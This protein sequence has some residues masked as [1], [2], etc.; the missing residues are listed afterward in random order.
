EFYRQLEAAPQSAKTSQPPPGD[1][2]RLF[3]FLTSHY[4]AVVAVHLSARASGTWNAAVSAAERVTGRPIRVIDSRNASLGQGLIALAAA[5]C[6]ANG[7][8]LE[9]VLAAAADAMRRTRTYALL[10]RLDYAV[11]GGRVPRFLQWIADML[12]CSPL[13]AT[14]PNGRVG[15]GG[16]IWSRRRARQRFARFIRRRLQPTRRYRLLVGHGN[17][18]EQGELL[19]QE[20]VAGLANI[21]SA[22]R[23]SIGT[24]LGVHGGPGMLVVGLQALP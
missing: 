18:P 13:L 10:V 11:R 19:L 15:F 22:E 6:A 23:V 4:E 17:S 16:V 24:A 1:F 7:G 12:H 20:I 5:E 21:V 9:Q 3:E 14:F 2:R 8:T